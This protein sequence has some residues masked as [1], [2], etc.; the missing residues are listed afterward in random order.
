[1]GKLQ[2][3]KLRKKIL[4][5][6]FQEK[7]AHKEI[8][9]PPLNENSIELILIGVKQILKSASLKAQINTNKYNLKK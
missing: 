4:E 2:P 1:M 6:M 8:L 7:I 5:A 3:I 9:I